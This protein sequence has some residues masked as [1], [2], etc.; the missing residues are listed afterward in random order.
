MYGLR[1]GPRTGSWGSL[2]I[3]GME[4]GRA[5]GTGVLSVKRVWT[6]S[7]KTW[8]AHPGGHAP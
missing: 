5:Q 2:H 4:G 1:T 8:L 3:K 7:L 6:L